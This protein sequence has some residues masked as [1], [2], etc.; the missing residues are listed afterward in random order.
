MSV[1]FDHAMLESEERRALR[2]AVAAL[3]R[4]FGREYFTTAV[5]EGRQTD[6]LWQE[7]GKLGYLGVNL[8]E[9]YGGGGGGCR[10]VRGAGGAGGGRMPAAA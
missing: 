9:E 3:G 5:R 10:T 1:T 7:A 8:P 4:R 6:E 2:A